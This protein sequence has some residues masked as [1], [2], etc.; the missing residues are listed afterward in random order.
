MSGQ[1]LVNVDMEPTPSTSTTA[2]GQ[3]AAAK[4]ALGPEGDIRSYQNQTAEDI[5]SG[6]ARIN[7]VGSYGSGH[8]EDALLPEVHV[9]KK[10]GGNGGQ[11]DA[12]LSPSRRLRSAAEN[13]PLL[14]HHHR[15]SSYED[16]DSAN[17]SED[18]L[19]PGKSRL[20]FRL[21]FILA[22]LEVVSVLDVKRNE[23]ACSQRSET[24][25]FSKSN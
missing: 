10:S 7:S 25:R 21:L 22:R 6:R 15:S 13:Q 1:V 19:F 23:A 17:D 24:C 8:S 18:N 20:N 3:E 9:I 2:P 5:E 4:C 16:I 11:S 12:L 14:R